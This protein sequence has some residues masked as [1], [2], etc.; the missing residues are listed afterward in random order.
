MEQ[1]LLS[2]AAL[3]IS[4][5]CSV[6]SRKF[7]KE[8]DGVSTVMPALRL[9]SGQAPA[10]IQTPLIVLDSGSRFLAKAGITPARPE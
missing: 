9:G 7:A 8:V 3:F 4:V 10:G 1:S 6:L 5:Q 2:F